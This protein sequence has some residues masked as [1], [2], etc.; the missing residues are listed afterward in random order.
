[1]DGTAELAKPLVPSTGY[2]ETLQFI[3]SFILAPP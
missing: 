3:V 1:M 2:E